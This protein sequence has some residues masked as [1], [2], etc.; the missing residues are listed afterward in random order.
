[1][2]PARTN[3]RLTRLSALLGVLLVV[4]FLILVSAKT[5]SGT[6]AI[7]AV[8]ISVGCVSADIGGQLAHVRRLVGKVDRGRLAATDQHLA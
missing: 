6:P 4:G 7:G 2:G 1:L 3:G 8:V 5:S